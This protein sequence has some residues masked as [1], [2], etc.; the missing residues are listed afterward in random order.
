MNPAQLL[1]VSFLL[2]PAGVCVAAQPTV[3]PG[4][5]ALSSNIPSLLAKDTAAGGK[6][7]SLSSRWG[8]YFTI[9]E[10][11]SGASQA[12][13]SILSNGGVGIGTTSPT[14]KLAVN[15]TI[16]AKE[17]IV[18]TSVWSDYVFADDYVLAPLAEVE[19]H[20]KEHKHLP[21]VPSASEV[22]E[23]E[24]LSAICR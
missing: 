16:K 2:V 18:E 7:Y 23:K 1:L 8:G 17:V 21:G 6:T 9:F 14:H 13:F 5:V 22:S 3:F 10:E 20:I 24:S 15:G 19:A 12:R 4:N 11:N